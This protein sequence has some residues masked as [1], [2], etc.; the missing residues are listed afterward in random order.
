MFLIHQIFHQQSLSG[1]LKNLLTAEKNWL[2]NGLN[3]G[4]FVK[5]RVIQRSLSSLLDFLRIKWYHAIIIS[6]S[7][8]F[9]DCTGFYLFDLLMLLKSTRN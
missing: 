6:M 2:Y 5:N 4:G 8:I 1:S 7:Y 9:L 3:A